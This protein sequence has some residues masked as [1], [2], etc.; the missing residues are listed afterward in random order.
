MEKAIRVIILSY[1]R[2]FIRCLGGWGGI[3]IK[4]AVYSKII[5]SSARFAITKIVFFFKVL[6]LLFWLYYWIKQTLVRILSPKFILRPSFSISALALNKTLISME[7]DHYEYIFD[8]KALSKQFFFVIVCANIEVK[9]YPFKYKPHTIVRPKNRKG[10]FILSSRIGVKPIIRFAC[11]QCNRNNN[12]NNNQAKQYEI[13]ITQ[14]NSMSVHKNES[15]SIQ[16]LKVKQQI[17]LNVFL[18]SFFFQ[19]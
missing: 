18:I 14:I 16:K 11:L 3:F 5:G 15:I 6:S 9:K 1:C 8:L 4:P 7:N 12:K 19:P 10:S 2:L 13:K 17:K